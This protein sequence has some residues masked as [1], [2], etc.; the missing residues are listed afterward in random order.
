MDI[1]TGLG[2][3]A[4][5]FVLVSLILMGGE[6]SMFADTH[7]AIVIFGGLVS[8]TLLDTLLTPVLFLKFGRKS[9]ERLVVAQDGS[10]RPA[11]AF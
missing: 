10:M 5:G 6:L 2:L 7:A 3:L 8:A 11:E 4:G 1:A 9:V